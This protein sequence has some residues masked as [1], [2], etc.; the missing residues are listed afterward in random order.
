[1]LKYYRGAFIFLATTLLLHCSLFKRPDFNRDGG[2]RLTAQLDMASMSADEKNNAT[3]R[4]LEIVKKRLKD[5]EFKGAVLRKQGPDAVFL[6][7]PGFYDMDRVKK[8]LFA[9]ALLEFKMVREGEFMGPALE[10]MDRFFKSNGK[11]GNAS[12]PAD[13]DLT[14]EQKEAA[15]IQKELEA[16]K[17]FTTLLVKAG[18]D[19]AV[20][21]DN[22]ARV[23]AMLD[24]AAK[25][26]VLQQGVEFAWG[27]EIEGQP[28]SQ[29]RRLYLLKSNPELTGSCLK[30]AKPSIS[31]GMSSGAVVSLTLTSEG[32]QRF[33]RITGANI[34]KRL[35]IVLDGMVF[36]AP[37]IRS[38]IPN[39]KAD[40][41]G[42]ANYEEA[43]DLSVV[44]R[45]G[46]LPGKVIFLE[47][48]VI[49][50]KQQ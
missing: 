9:S 47:E 27:N 20:P 32:A 39:G 17:P 28:G 30:D 21:Q 37:V 4:M 41:S 46:A 24:E 34:D 8:Y 26:Y 2:I 14:P 18:Y 44:L 50:P 6:E 16:Q 38:K 29:F 10:A 22:I 49:K 12:V 13:A 25:A 1:M 5:F 31:Q 7:V 43:R 42:M 40:I 33:A 11:T 19:V 3:D 48:H 15:A 35:A 45:A 36:S 23:R